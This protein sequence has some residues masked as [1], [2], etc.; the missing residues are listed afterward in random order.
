MKI[1]HVS[2][3][4]VVSN[5]ALKQLSGRWWMLNPTIICSLV[6]YLYLV[7]YSWF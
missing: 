7:A 2:T 6:Y 4:Q 3:P 1:K 5:R